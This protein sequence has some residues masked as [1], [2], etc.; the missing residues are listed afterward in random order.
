MAYCNLTS[1]ESVAVQS[2]FKTVGNIQEKFV[3][4]FRW[5]EKVELIRK[6]ILI[7]KVFEAYNYFHNTFKEV[8]NV[9]GLKIFTT[10]IDCDSIIF[11]AKGDVK[12]SSSVQDF[13]AILEKN[14]TQYR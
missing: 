1:T 4:H 8:P 3:S 11:D 13:F 2:V 5:T 12:G 14:L 10:L 6:N 7:Q 9:S